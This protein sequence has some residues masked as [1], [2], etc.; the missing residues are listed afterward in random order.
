MPYTRCGDKRELIVRL[1]EEDTP[2][3]YKEIDGKLKI[4]QILKLQLH[5][6]LES[7]VVT[8]SHQLK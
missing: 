1:L 2:T 7:K 5:L 4:Q 8:E 3:N 6:R